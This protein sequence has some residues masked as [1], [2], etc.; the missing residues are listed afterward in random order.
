[1]VV[2]WADLIWLAVVVWS[3]GLILVVWSD[4][5][6]VWELMHGLICGRI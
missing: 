5:G 1:M 6:L 2:C 4:D 3:D